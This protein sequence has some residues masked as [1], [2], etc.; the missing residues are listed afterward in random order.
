MV[1]KGAFQ[2]S[3]REFLLGEKLAYTLAVSE[4]CIPEALSLIQRRYFKR[5][6]ADLPHEQEPSAEHLASVDNGAPD[7]ETIEPDKDKLPPAEYALEMKRI[8]D[9]RNVVNYRKGVS[10]TSVLRHA[11]LN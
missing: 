3:R 8:E 1:N 2:G 6:P 7:P 5:Y 9:R 10:T 11:L 4:G